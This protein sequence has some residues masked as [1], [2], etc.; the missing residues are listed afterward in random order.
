MGRIKVVKRGQ[1]LR[2]GVIRFSIGRK[3]SGTG[4]G[5]IGVHAL[6]NPFGVKPHGPYTR[7]ESLSRYEVWL[8]HKI[9]LGTRTFALRSTQSGKR[10]DKGRWNS[11][12]FA[13]P[14]AATAILLS[15]PSRESFE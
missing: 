3:S 8:E 4:R 2:A 6:G 11:S 1:R 5:C 7:E 12:A 9:A 10:R 14:K 15:A 13:P